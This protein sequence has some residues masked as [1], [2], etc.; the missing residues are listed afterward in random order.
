VVVTHNESL[1]SQT[2][3]LITLKDGIKIGDTC[4][5]KGEA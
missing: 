4:P 5:I 1:A 3:R 2:P